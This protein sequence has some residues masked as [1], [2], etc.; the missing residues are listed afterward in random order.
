MVD[1]ITVH[2]ASCN[3]TLCMRIQSMKRRE[4]SQIVI[5]LDTA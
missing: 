4:M 1:Q 5:I 2:S 3:I